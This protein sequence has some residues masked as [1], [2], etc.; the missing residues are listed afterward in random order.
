MHHKVA[1]YCTFYVRSFLF[2]LSQNKFLYWKLILY[3]GNGRGN[4]GIVHHPVDLLFRSAKQNQINKSFLEI[5]LTKTTGSSTWHVVGTSSL[6]IL[7]FWAYESA[8]LHFSHNHL[9]VNIYEQSQK[10]SLSLYCIFEI[11]ISDITRTQDKIQNA[12]I[13][14][15][16]FHWFDKVSGA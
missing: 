13:S 4:P 2:Y 1:L 5:K 12:E 15:H 11:L 3:S 9:A 16:S 6:S 8:T 14:F 7:S 10:K